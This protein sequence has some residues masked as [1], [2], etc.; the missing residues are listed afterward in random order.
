MT[1]HPLMPYKR[2]AN[3][4]QKGFKRGLR[5]GFKWGA[6]GMQMGC[7]QYPIPKGIG[8]FR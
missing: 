4:V 8:V 6:K 1:G 3:G 7:L 5:K 2:G